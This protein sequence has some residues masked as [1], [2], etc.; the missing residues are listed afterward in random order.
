MCGVWVLHVV[1]SVSRR[2][3]L[4]LCSMSARLCIIVE[5]VQRNNQSLLN[6]EKVSLMRL[7]WGKSSFVVL[8]AATRINFVL[9]VLQSIVGTV[10]VT[11]LLLQCPRLH[12]FLKK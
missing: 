5:I 7:Q 4:R 10:E 9:I 3:I 12:S 2:L 8:R 11:S 1:Q 6:Q